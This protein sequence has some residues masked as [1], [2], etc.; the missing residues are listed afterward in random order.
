VTSQP[1]P[2]DLLARLA[3]GLA[4][5]VTAR[6]RI[7]RA[8]AIAMILADW[9]GRPRLVA[10]AA[11]ASSPAEVR[12]LRVY[13]DAAA[14]T[15]R[16]IYHRLRRYRAAET[17]F[18]D[19]VRAFAGLPPGSPP[20]LV[21]ERATAIA[22][23]HVS[24]AERLPHLSEFMAA[25]TAAAGTFETV[26][27][28]GCGVL[29]LLF[30]FDSPACSGVREYWAMDKDHRAITALRE[31][32]RVRADQRIRPVHWNIADG[33]QPAAAAGLP[34]RCDLGLLL[35]V[36]PVVRR[37]EPGLL[38]TLAEIPADRLVISGSR[39]AMA[40]RRDIERRETRE[41]QRFC[42]EHALT[43]IGRF[44]TADEICLVAQRS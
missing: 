15:K 34:A 23:A 25:L 28:A 26:I 40:K 33:W 43:E 41:L 14:A 19:A 29:P 30:P 44:R 36:V 24:T 12:R 6:Y 10:A 8:D 16:D 1:V 20:D 22:A 37:Q 31:Y 35:K 2:D 4:D 21:A 18:D 42:A 38:R 13:R 39:M 32:A 5:Q 7:D 11:S 27:D 3:A 17:A 9:E